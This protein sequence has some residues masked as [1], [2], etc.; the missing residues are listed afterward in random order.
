MTPDERANNFQRVYYRIEHERRV[1]KKR[2]RGYLLS[3][4]LV[5]VLLS[6]A[7]VIA[8]REAGKRLDKIYQVGGK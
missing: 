1:E 2:L 3:C 6:V 7:A 8:Y 4:F 5:F